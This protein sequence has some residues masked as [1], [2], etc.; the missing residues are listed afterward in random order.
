MRSAYAVAISDGK[1]DESEYTCLFEV[2]KALEMTNAHIQGVI[3]HHE[4]FLLRSAKD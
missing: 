1:L 2:G 4:V 3:A